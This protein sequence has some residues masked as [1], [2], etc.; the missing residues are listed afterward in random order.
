MVG[1]SLLHLFQ[2]ENTAD[3]HV[4]NSLTSKSDRLINILLESLFLLLFQNNILIRAQIN[5]YTQKQIAFQTHY[6][7]RTGPEFDDSQLL[8]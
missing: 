5:T 1:F 7:V 2:I 3:L 4:L 8:E 6:R